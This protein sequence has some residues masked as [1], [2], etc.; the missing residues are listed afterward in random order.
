MPLLFEATIDV[1]IFEGQESLSLSFKVPG[2]IVIAGSF[3]QDC[4]GNKTSI[5]NVVI[6]LETSILL[7]SMVRQAKHLAKKSFQ[8]ALATLQFL[9]LQ[10]SIS[11]MSRHGTDTRIESSS[12]TA[13]E[14]SEETKMQ[15]G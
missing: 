8:A 14:T 7:D 13:S 10:Q 1:T 4:F 2:S 15:S 3:T 11:L 5:S 6:N 12:N 9:E